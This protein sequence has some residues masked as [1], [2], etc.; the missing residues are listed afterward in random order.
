MPE[1]KGTFAPFAI[2]RKPPATIRPTTPAQA[3]VAR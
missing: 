1:A 3:K 2:A